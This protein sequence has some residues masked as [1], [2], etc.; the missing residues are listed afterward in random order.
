MLAQ[1][2]DIKFIKSY[3]A[4]KKQAFTSKEPFGS[5]KKENNETSIYLLSNS[6]NFQILDLLP[7]H[8]TITTKNSSN[9][10]N[11]DVL[12]ETSNVIKLLYQENPNIKQ[13][14]IDIQDDKNVLEKFSK[15]YQGEYVQFNKDDAMISQTIAEK[16]LIDIDFFQRKT[17]YFNI[18][19]S[20]VNNYIKN[21]KH[22]LFTIQTKRNEYK[23]NIFGILSSTVIREI[24]LKE[25][26]IRQN[27]YFYDFDDEE[28]EFQFI[29]D[30]FNFKYVQLTNLNVDKIKEI[31]EDLGI[32]F[33][34]EMIFKLCCCL[35]INQML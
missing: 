16:L 31:A 32:D 11:I 1:R 21:T 19:I 9:K 2:S 28:N 20:S 30:I 26:E 17:F 18:Y 23:C 7:R 24:L 15:L 5:S 34:I 35:W 6:C 8:F 13:Y 10:F 25:S 29:C 3:S 33:L 22:C 27:S 4:A 12:S 14:H